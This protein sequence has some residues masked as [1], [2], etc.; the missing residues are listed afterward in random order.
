MGIAC[1]LAS[2]SGQDDGRTSD[3]WVGKTSFAQTRRRSGR[4][5]PLP[6]LRRRGRRHRRR[7]HPP[8]RRGPRRG[9]L[10]ESPAET[11][12]GRLDVAS[13]LLPIGAPPRGAWQRSASTTEPDQ[14]AYR[15]GR[16]SIRAPCGPPRPP[17]RPSTRSNRTRPL[18][19]P[20]RGVT[21]LG[22]VRKR[23]SAG[24]GDG[25]SQSV[26]ADDRPRRWPRD[27]RG[28]LR[29]DGVGSAE[30]VAG[31]PGSSPRVEI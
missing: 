10:R 17:T 21:S 27:R 14:T 8:P 28:I 2:R 31:R 29:D 25:P 9:M 5:R 4:D 20:Q 1:M 12:E 3:L 23:M 26:G 16:Q 22:I 11:T 30:D 15:P 24:S 13:P 7:N 18:S 19:S 6:Q